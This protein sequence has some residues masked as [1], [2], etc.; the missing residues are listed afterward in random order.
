MNWSGV[1]SSAPG[2]HGDRCNKERTCTSASQPNCLR[3]SAI[4]HSCGHSSAP[5]LS[6]Y[7]GLLSKYITEEE[8]RAARQ[9]PPQVRSNRRSFA[10]GADYV[11]EM[12]RQVIFE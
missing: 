9:E 3:Y 11:A 1:M 4:A 8:H 7:Y 12:A 2:R 5:R 6:P 10:V